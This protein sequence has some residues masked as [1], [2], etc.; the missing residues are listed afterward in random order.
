MQRCWCRTLTLRMLASLAFLVCPACTVRFLIID[1]QQDEESGELPRAYVVMKAGKVATEAEIQGENSRKFHNA[2]Q[3]V[4]LTFAVTAVPID[5]Y[6]DHPRF[7]DFVAKNVA[8]HKKLRGGVV[9]L[10]TI[11]KS[12]SGKILR[13]VLRD[14]AKIEIAKTKNNESI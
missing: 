14:Q 4:S 11:P 8:Q 10:D 5:A 9:F 2:L 12:T 13:R 1:F 6:T 3:F 7:L